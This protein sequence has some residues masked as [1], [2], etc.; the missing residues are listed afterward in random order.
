MA[1]SRPAWIYGTAT[2]AS[3]TAWL[4]RQ[5]GT[6]YSVTGKGPG[7]RNK[8]RSQYTSGLVAGR[9]YRRNKMAS[10]GGTPMNPAF[11]A[12]FTRGLSG[13][14]VGGM[15]AGGRHSSFGTEVVKRRFLPDKRWVPVGRS[16]Q[17]VRTSGK[18]KAGWSQSWKEVLHPRGFGGKFRRK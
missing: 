2:S 17:R 13:G 15:R 12:G 14:L 10:G 7:S 9:R 5:G 6:G 11:N 1:T 16:A 8:R 18:V 3:L 4:R